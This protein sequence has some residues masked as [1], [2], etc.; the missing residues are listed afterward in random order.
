MTSI[1]LSGEGV[2]PGCAYPWTYAVMNTGNS[3][4][5]FTVPAGFDAEAKGVIHKISGQMQAGSGD[6]ATSGAVTGLITFQPANYYLGND[7]NFYLGIEQDKNQATTLTGAAMT[8]VFG[9]I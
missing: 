8:N 6:P 2:T 4:K 5:L 1:T 7:G 3:Y 9:I